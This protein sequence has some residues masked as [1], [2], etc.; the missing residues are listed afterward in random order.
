[1]TLFVESVCY[2]YRGN[3]ISTSGT[4]SYGGIFE[5]HANANGTWTEK[6]LHT[7]SGGNDGSAPYGGQLVVDSAGNLYGQAYNGARDFGLVFE[8]VRG[9]NG[10]W[11]EK[12]LHTFTGAADGF[13]VAPGTLVIDASGNILGTSV[14]N[15][16]ELVPDLNGTRTEKILH[17][18][19]GGSDGAYLEAGLTLSTSGTLYGTTYY[20]GMHHGT[21]FQLT[22]GSN[23]TWTEKVLHR[24]TATGGDGIYP[25][26]PLVV[27]AHGNLFGTT[28]DGGISNNGVVFEVT[29]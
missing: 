29:P 7:F 26:S 25:N 20:G 6:V 17:T 24:F 12:T 23:G 14:W 8:L 2:G 10:S 18:F 21:V 4:T 9:L 22:P 27:D 3:F 11:S 1:V 5:I 16:F 28:M 15:A 19:N 13:S